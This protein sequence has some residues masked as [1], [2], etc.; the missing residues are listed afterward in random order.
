MRTLKEIDEDVAAKAQS[1]AKTLSSPFF[2]F[3]ENEIILV[4]SEMQ[5]GDKYREMYAILQ[6]LNEY[7]SFASLDGKEERQVLRKKLKEM[8][9]NL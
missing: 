8:L 4:N 9:D 2:P 5:Y 1:R 6:T 7:L 3:T